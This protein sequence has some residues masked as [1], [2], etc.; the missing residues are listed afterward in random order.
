M[1]DHTHIK[2][3]SQ[4][5]AAT[6]VTL[7]ALSET[8]SGPAFSRSWTNECMVIQFKPARQVVGAQ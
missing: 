2:L 4:D 3:Q 6:C 7:I 5:V 1:L 8:V